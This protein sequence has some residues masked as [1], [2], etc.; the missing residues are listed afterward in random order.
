MDLIQVQQPQQL[1]LGRCLVIGKMGR[2][3]NKPAFLPRLES[4]AG[5]RIG[6]AGCA[7]SS[8]FAA[9]PS[10]TNSHFSQ[11][12]LR[13]PFACFYRPF[14]IRPLRP[15]PRLT[16]RRCLLGPLRWTAVAAGS[17]TQRWTSPMKRDY[18][19]SP[20]LMMPVENPNQTLCQTVHL[21]IHSISARERLS[22]CS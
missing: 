3:Q 19:E 14:A 9:T 13:P 22:T 20:R 16:P 1:I 10:S 2:S 7:A 12:F 15:R 6:L 11:H 21:G 17:Q 18:G 5:V 8:P 4:S